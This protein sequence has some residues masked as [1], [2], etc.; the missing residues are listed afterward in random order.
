M[1][2]NAL[3]L[4]EANTQFVLYFSQVKVAVRHGQSII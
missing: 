2:K 1:R 4:Y 3:L